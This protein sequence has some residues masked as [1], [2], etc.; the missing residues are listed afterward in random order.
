MVWNESSDHNWHTPGS[1]RGIASKQ[2]MESKNP[3]LFCGACCALYRVSFYWGEAERSMGGV[4]PLELT[5]ELT[6]FR[7]CMKGTSRKPVRCIALQGHIGE[8]VNC[9]IYLARPTPCR[10]FGVTWSKEGL[11]TGP[12]E[13]ERCNRARAVWGL[14]PLSTIMVGEQGPRMHL[15][16]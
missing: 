14:P 7:R 10:E 11:H 3:C 16:F 4:V 5:E 13:L 8:I 6:P 2:S 9:T 1:I 15:P 12:G